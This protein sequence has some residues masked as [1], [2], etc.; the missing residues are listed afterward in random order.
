[1]AAAVTPNSRVTLKN[2][3]LNKTRIEAYKIL[4]K[5]GAHV[6]FVKKEDKYESTGDITVRSAPLKAVE[7][8]E[9][10]SW[11]I[12]ELPALSIVFACALGVSSVKNAKELRVKESD[13]I[14]TIV[15]NL[16]LCGIEAHEREDGYD[17]KGGEFKS[18]K[19]DSFGD[20]RIAMSFAIAALTCGG[21]IS[22][23]ECINTSFPNFID[24]LSLL[25]KVEQ[26]R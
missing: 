4:Q 1:A 3:L 25:T 24:I 7:V 17:I 20:H 9:N 5:M 12:D 19:V 26:C 18:F 13:R 22:D 23:T 11:L 10:I 6:E 15:E 21:G 2:V 14:K 16:K 8:S